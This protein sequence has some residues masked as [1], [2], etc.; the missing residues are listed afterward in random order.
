[1]NEYWF[2]DTSSL[3]LDE[4]DL[5]AENH[6]PVIISSITLD[7]LEKIKTSNNKDLDTK[8]AAEHLIKKLKN[9]IGKYTV[10]I[11]NTNMLVP[12]EEKDL[13]ITYDTKILSCAI[14]YDKK[15]HPDEVIFIT[16]DLSLFNIANLFF[17]E[18]S[19]QMITPK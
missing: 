10:W 19:I 6:P 18:D 2:Y 15:V 4:D 16:N 14:D 8:I 5:F 1:M 17:G 3:L 12:I 13:E 9:N 7:E 11:F